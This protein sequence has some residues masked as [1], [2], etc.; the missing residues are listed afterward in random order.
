MNKREIRKLMCA[1]LLGD[2]SITRSKVKNRKDYFSHVF[3]F[4]HSTKQEDYLLYKVQLINEI[5]EQKNLD[6][7]MKT[8]NYTAKLVYKDVPKE[9]SVVKA[10]LS[11]E[12]YFK[13]FYYRAYKYNSV[14]DKYKKSM[15][16]LLSQI[17]SDK[18]LFL[19]FADDG[20]EIRTKKKH[21]R[22]GEWTGDYIGNPKL[23]LYTNSCTQGEINLIIEWFK[24][25]YSVTPMQN[26]SGK[27]NNSKPILNFSPKDSKLLFSH[28]AVYVKQIPSMRHK[29]RLS[30]ERYC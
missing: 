14:E 6:R 11:W 12:T 3:A 8:H 29:F 15:E 21:K 30:L 20:C 19:W 22:S 27:V 10:K 7:R 26:H 13:L 18:H 24:K 17:D 4:S 16:Y 9:Y 2:A 25:N 23:R 1:M 5:F 28:I